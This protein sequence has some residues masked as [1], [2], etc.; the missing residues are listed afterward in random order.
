MSGWGGGVFD[1]EGFL[2]SNSISVCSEDILRVESQRRVFDNVSGWAGR[3]F[4]GESSFF[5]SFQI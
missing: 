5:A 4:L 3:V 2:L 1:G